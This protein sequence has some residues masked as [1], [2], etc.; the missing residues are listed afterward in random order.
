MTT[1]K[2]AAICFW[3]AVG[4]AVS[5]TMLFWGSWFIILISWIMAFPMAMLLASFAGFFSG[6]L[7]E[8]VGKSLKAEFSEQQPI[9]TTLGQMWV[10]DSDKL[11]IETSSQI[12]GTFQGEPLYE[13][14]ML[15]PPDGSAPVKCYYDRTV[16]MSDFEL[17][18]VEVPADAWYCVTA[19]GV[20]YVQKL[21]PENSQPEV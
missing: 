15:A 1:D 4:M 3:A 5:M 16:Y 21:E 18:N 6:M 9:E 12:I 17:G 8:T 2:L 13:W 14:V 10:N 20:M 19:P 11:I 7:D